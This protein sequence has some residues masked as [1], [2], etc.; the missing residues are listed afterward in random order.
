M[1]THKDNI[2]DMA[3]TTLANKPWVGISSTAGGGALSVM[4]VMTPYLEFSVIVM[5]FMI[6]VITLVGLARKHI[7]N[8]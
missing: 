5:S 3:T 1:T 8:G 2:L 4:N 7:F 6:G